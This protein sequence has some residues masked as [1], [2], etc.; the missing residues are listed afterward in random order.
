MKR[1]VSAL[2]LITALIS[3]SCTQALPVTGEYLGVRTW[4]DAPLDGSVIPLAPYEIVFHVSDTAGIASAECMIDEAAVAFPG[5]GADSVLIQTFRHLW[6]PA[7]PGEYLIV[8]RGQNPGGTWSEPADALVVV[9]GEAEELVE[10]DEDLLP[11]AP[12][13]E[14]APSVTP[15]VEADCV[16]DVDYLA[17][18]TIPDGTLMTPGETFQ[19]TWRFGNSGTCPIDSS[20]DF[21]YF[22]AERMNGPWQ[23][24]A[25]ASVPGEEFDL[26]LSFT[27]PAEPGQHESVYRFRMPDGEW[28][29]SRP[30]VRIIVEGSDPTDPAPACSLASPGPYEPANG[31][32]GSSSLTLKW[33]Y[34]GSGCTPG[35]YRV[36][37]STS[38]DFS[39]DVKTAEVGGLSYDTALGGC[40]TYYWRV[41]A[42]SG[43]SQGPWSS[44]F[45]FSVVCPYT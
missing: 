23:V 8:C 2:T 3:V 10:L 27:A 1:L 33:S 31:A 5:G 4:I 21:A 28:F 44:I 29:G 22:G 45:K 19:K 34:S 6:E 35:G 14:V 42:L 38:S 18:I 16:F 13:P 32:E 15:T 20:F 43:S 9:A 7:E 26:T 39:S 17:N 24:S 30:Y 41:R 25:P 36:Q 37:I 11:P 40:T 12:T